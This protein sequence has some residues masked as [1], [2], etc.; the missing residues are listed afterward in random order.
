M[1]LHL[2]FFRGKRSIKWYLHK[3]LKWITCHI[4]H[5]RQTVQNLWSWVAHSQ[6]IALW[7]SYL[8]IASEWNSFF[9]GPFVTIKGKESKDRCSMKHKLWYIALTRRRK[10]IELLWCFNSLSSIMQESNL[11]LTLNWLTQQH[12]EGTVFMK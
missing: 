6:H 7:L 1:F 11:S 5:R 12:L 9:L 2:L 8:I 10:D 4:T 3:R